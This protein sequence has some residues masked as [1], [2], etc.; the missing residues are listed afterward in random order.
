MQYLIACRCQLVHLCTMNPDHIA[1]VIE[2]RRKQLN[3]SMADVHDRAF[4][5]TKATAIQNI[6]RGTPPTVKTLS[7]LC[8]AL[9][10]EFYIGPPISSGAKARA[11]EAAEHLTDRDR[12]LRAITVVETGLDAA[13]RKIRPQKKAEIIMV[14]YDLLADGGEAAED[15]VIRL[16]R[17][18]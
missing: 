15:N 6:K 3:M 12:L 8:D 2:A 1:E 16:L 9:G 13:R 5:G 14:A 18:V 17:A 4:P 10:L 7:A 11:A